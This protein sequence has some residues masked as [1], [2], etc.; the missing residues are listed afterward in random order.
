M[1]PTQLG[2][3]GRSGATNATDGPDGDVR[4]DA[5]CS[6]SLD[7]G[8][9]LLRRDRHGH[10][11]PHPV[12]PSQLVLAT[13]ALAACLGADPSGAA[14]TAAP[15]E[16]PVIVQATSVAD[17]Q[18]PLSSAFASSTGPFELVLAPGRYDGRDVRLRD[19]AGERAI[20]VRSEGP[21]PAVLVGARL[22]V[23]G[24]ALVVQGV[25]I[26]GYAGGEAAL[27]LEFGQSATLRDVAV[28][29]TR[30]GSESRRPPVSLQGLRARPTTA[31]FDGA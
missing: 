13:L 21:E 3:V 1:N 6:M 18:G 17:L 23:R 2:R 22:S 4:D 11:R 12:R 30:G 10:P 7:E 28:V 15:Q 24:G 14:S 31:T 27:D 19:T 16:E 5:P 25:A 8:A 9:A 20:T 26:E 29:R